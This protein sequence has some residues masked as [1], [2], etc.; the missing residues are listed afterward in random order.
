MDEIKLLSEMCAAELIAANVEPTDSNV[1]SGHCMSNNQRESDHLDLSKLS[2]NLKLKLNDPATEPSNS[3]SN[4]DVKVA[5]GFNIVND[6]A[7]QTNECGILDLDSSLEDSTSSPVDGIIETKFLE[8]DTFQNASLATGAH[9]IINH[10]NEETSLHLLD[11]CKGNTAHTENTDTHEIIVRENE[12]PF[13]DDNL[14]VSS[15][16]TSIDAEPLENQTACI[17][18]NGDICD[19]SSS[20][21]MLPAHTL[22][23][24]CQN[25]V[26]YDD[27]SSCLL[28][29][30]KD[31]YKSNIKKVIATGNTNVN[32]LSIVSNKQCTETDVGNQTDTLEDML[33]GTATA[34]KAA[35]GFANNNST[36]D[37]CNSTTVIEDTNNDNEIDTENIHPLSSEQKCSTVEL[38]T[39]GTKSELEKKFHRKNRQRRAKVKNKLQEDLLQ[40]K[41]KK[42]VDFKVYESAESNCLYMQDLLLYSAVYKTLFIIEQFMLKLYR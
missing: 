12:T 40:F 16:L 20:C 3:K 21:V 2:L 7:L 1:A 13:N 42:P 36:I 37:Q 18:S 30:R 24:Q 22:T 11:I 19:A 23:D 14:I 33:D 34:D 38:G 15:N 39:T 17:S 31:D 6:V 35:I 9:T 29:N 8:N 41:Y 25:V 10:D 28:S 4:H 5:L 27:A 32:A 26:E